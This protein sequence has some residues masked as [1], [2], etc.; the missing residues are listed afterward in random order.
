MPFVHSSVRL[1][2]LL[3]AAV[4]G[5]NGAPFGLDHVDSFQ[6]AIA[7]AGHQ[8]RNTPVSQSITTRA[9]GDSH[10]FCSGELVVYSVYNRV[11]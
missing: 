2:Q 7:L 11:F 3:Q 8:P 10:P 4:V 5:Q 6:Q 1:D 9:V